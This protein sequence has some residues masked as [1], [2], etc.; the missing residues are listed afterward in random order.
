LRNSCAPHLPS[1]QTTPTMENAFLQSNVHLH[2]PK[3]PQQ[4][5]P[6]TMSSPTLPNL[7]SSPLGSWGTPISSSP[8]SSAHRHHHP[9]TSNISLR[10][11]DLTPEPPQIQ[12]LR[13]LQCNNLNTPPLRM[14]HDSGTPSTQGDF[15]ANN[16]RGRPRADVITNLILEGSSS[17]SEIKCKVCNRV[18]PREKSLQVKKII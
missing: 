3:R 5:Q 14:R 4:P 1:F 2:T 7:M 13:H 11:M 8:P 16:K 9:A 18:F 17:P 10:L 6:H 12:H 15:G